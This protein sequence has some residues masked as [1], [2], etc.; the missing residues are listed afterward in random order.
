MTDEPV[1]YQG[2]ETLLEAWAPALRGPD[3]VEFK[4]VLVR[5]NMQPAIASYIRVPGES[6]YRGFAL[7]MLRVEEGKVAEISAFHPDLFEAFGLPA[8]ISDDD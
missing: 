3:A 5:A 2:R 8:E 6:V 7:D 1:W 4:N